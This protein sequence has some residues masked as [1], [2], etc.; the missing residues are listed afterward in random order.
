MVEPGPLLASG[1]D[2]DIFD[3]GDGTV[4]RRTKRGR[5]IEDEA[6]IMRHVVEHGYPAPVVHDV[7]ADGTEIVMDRVDGPMMM[8]PM[9][10]RPWTMARLAGVLADL[11]D[12]LHRI[13]APDWLPR[14]D[15]GDRVL[16]LDLHPLN[17]LM[18]P[19]GPVVI[20]WSNAARGDPLTDVASTYVLL[21]TPE[22]PGPKLLRTAIQPVRQGL[23]RSFTRRY[24]GPEL[25]A[26]I[27]VAAELKTVDPNMSPGEVE[28]LRRLATRMRRRVR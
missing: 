14:L 7:R 3:L 23:G 19:S 26:R 25:D 10:K 6:R 18:S 16:H 20:D 12:A 24:R 9:L 11:H 22:M 17:V 21:T 13:P 1:R 8:D 2:A 15:N 5:S 28:N 4:L 27:A